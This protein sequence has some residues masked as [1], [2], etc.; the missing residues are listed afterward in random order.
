MSSQLTSLTYYQVAQAKKQA[1]FYW[2][3]CKDEISTQERIW[4]TMFLKFEHYDLAKWS[5]SLWIFERTF[6]N[7]LTKR[8]Y[9]WIQEKNSK[10]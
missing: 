3:F 1:H 8:S 5:F 10:K 4:K 2:K 6:F 9:G 7:K